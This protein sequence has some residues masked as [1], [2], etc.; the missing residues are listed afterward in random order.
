VLIDFKTSE[1]RNVI[2]KEENVILKYKYLTTEIQCMGNIKTKVI[3]VIL[4]R[5]RRRW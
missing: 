1:D 4:G 3:S 5:P 2:K